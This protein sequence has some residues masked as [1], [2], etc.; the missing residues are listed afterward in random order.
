LNVKDIITELA[1][2]Q[3][4]LVNSHLADLSQVTF[5]DLKEFSNVW[6]RIDVKRRREIISRLIDFTADSV[7]LNFDVI[8]KFCLLDP[9]E[10]VRRQAIEGLWENEDPSLIQSFIDLLLKDPS[11]KVQTAAVSALGKFALMSELGAIRAQYKNLLSKVL[12]A[13]LND[14][15]KHIEIR[16]RAL[17][18]VATLSTQQVKEAINK[19]YQSQNEQMK[20]GAI[21]AMGRNCDP[22]WMPLLLN[23]LSNR[24]AEIRY[25]AVSACG[26]MGSEE[27]VQHLITMI[28]DDDVDVRLA[29][30]QA[31]GKIGGE[32]SKQNLKKYAASADEVTR[33][34]IAQA[35]LEIETQDDMTIFQMPLQGDYED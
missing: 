29:A 33:E 7:E 15:G 24:D 34:A 23:E 32:E 3:K 2:I 4:P 31:L 1:D 22:D 12:L 16:R 8:Y 14:N 5:S 20:V 30:V 13:V 21:Y 28:K 25:E 10:D 18:A 6:N 17:E 19:A 35:L 9:D 26:E 11:E 27:I